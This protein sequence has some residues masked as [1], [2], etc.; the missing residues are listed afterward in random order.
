MIAI[1]ETSDMISVPELPDV[2]G[3]VFR[4]FRGESD[5]ANVLAVI[6]GSKQADGVE[7]SDTLEDVARNY[8]HLVNSDPYR[9]MI[10]AQVDGKVVG[11][12]RAEWRLTEKG[13]W[14]G[15]HLAFLLPGWRRQG[16]GRAMLRHLERRLSSILAQKRAGGSLPAETACYLDTFAFDTEVGKEILFAQEGYQPVRYEF[17]MVRPLDEPIQDHPMPAGLKVRPALPEHTRT[18]WDASQEAFRDH[19]GFIPATEE[20][21]QSWLE[22][23]EF[24]PSLWQVGWDGDQVAG[25]VLNFVNAEENREYGRKR[26]YTEGISVRRPWRRR[27]LARALLTRSLRMF[28]DMGMQEAALGVDRQNLSGALRLYESVGFRKV[29][30][31]AFYR[32]SLAEEARA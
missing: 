15:F 23:P 29:K 16:I 13:E 7:R 18:I 19:W 17:Q 24:A 12:G 26:G 28:R 1:E 32:K 30:Q 22:S 14:I 10:F 27:G 5:Y 31:M 8:S 20:E 4:R 9:D 6:R 25:M 3:L 11:Y 21:Y 2:P